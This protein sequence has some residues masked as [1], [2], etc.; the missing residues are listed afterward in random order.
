MN[1]FYLL[2]FTLLTNFLLAQSSKEIDSLNLIVKTTSNDSVKVAVLNKI[3]FHY[4]FHDSKK[5]LKIIKQSEKLAL[6]KKKLY[7]YN[8]TINIKGIINDIGGNSDSAN[9]YFQKSLAFSKKHH[10]GTMEARSLNGLGMNNWHKGNWKLALHYFFEA[11]RINE[12]LPENKK[13]NESICFNNIG[14]IYQE[15][16]LFDKAIVYHKK[17]YSIRLKDKLYKDQASSLN[18]LGICYRNKEEF[19]KAI[20]YYTKSI[21]VA[22]NSYN[23]IEY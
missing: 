5:A 15:M 22:K 13:I 7:G 18:N 21:N 1:K 8:E 4:V 10:F 16:K 11:L 17:S 12:M 19:D 14:L 20:F 23:L 6:S 9:Y 2:F 3:A